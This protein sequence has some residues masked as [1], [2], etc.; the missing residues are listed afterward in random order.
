M[1]FGIDVQNRDCNEKEIKQNYLNLSLCEKDGLICDSKRYEV[2]P[3]TGEEDIPP[4]FAK[5][6]PTAS[7]TDDYA[8]L[9]NEAS[10]GMSQ[11][12][13]I[14]DPDNKS[15][16]EF[17]FHH[18]IFNVIKSTVSTKNIYSQLVASFKEVTNVY[19][20]NCECQDVIEINNF[21]QKKVSQMKKNYMKIYR[22]ITMTLVRSL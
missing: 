13:V 11:D 22:T 20:G 17:P 21:F 1:T 18:L 16:D 3:V 14:F 8:I 2:L 7:V 5:Y 10:F 19:E 15:E 9:N 6:M 12:V 4:I